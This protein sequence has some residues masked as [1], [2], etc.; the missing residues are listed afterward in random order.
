MILL[1]VD[2]SM[3]ACSACVYDSIQNKVLAE[4]FEVMDRGQ[5]EALP[6]MVARVMAA[7]GISYRDLNRIGVTTGPGTFTGIRIGISFARGLA[8]SLGIKVVGVNSLVACQVAVISSEF[9]IFVTHKVGNSEFAT[10]IDFDNS[11]NIK[12]LK[13]IRLPPETVL[14]IGTAAEE[15]LAL[16]GRQNLKLLP[17]FNLPKASGFAHYISQLPDPLTT[18]GPTYGREADAKP[19]AT[20]LRAL[21]QLDVQLAGLD[22]VALLS[23]LHAA[24]FTPGW[25]ADAFTELLKGP[26]VAALVASSVEGPVGLLLYRC[27]ADEAEILT[28]GVHPALRRRGAGK[29]LLDSLLSLPIKTLFLEVSSQNE[30]AIKLY[31]K[32]GFVRKGVRKAYYAETGED[33]L[34]LRR[35]SSLL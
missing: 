23:N 31:E 24:C 17:V 28:F 22:E 12:L 8:L 16:S 26:G 30:D 27:V 14:V 20:L 11:I 29:A 15:V 18:P 10:V 6:P 34:I 19:H 21:P 5:A 25:S 3:A 7:S 1:A 9:P 13:D 2:T 32:A 4:E 33:A 35:D